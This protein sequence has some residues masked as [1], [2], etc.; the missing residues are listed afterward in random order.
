MKPPKTLPELSVKYWQPVKYQKIYRGAVLSVMR[1]MVGW[2]FEVS[3][4]G[5]DRLAFADK[6]YPTPLEAIYAAEK[7]ATKL[8]REVKKP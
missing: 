2:R 4:W 7:E 5:A 6:D 1:G 3:V 8:R